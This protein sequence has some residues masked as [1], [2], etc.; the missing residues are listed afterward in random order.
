MKT[1]KPQKRPTID[2]TAGPRHSPFRSGRLIVVAYAWAA[3]LGLVRTKG[4]MRLI[5]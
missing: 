5:C 2:R 1:R 4:R 3:D